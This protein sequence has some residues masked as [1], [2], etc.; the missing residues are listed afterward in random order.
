[1][2]ATTKTLLLA[3]LVAIT[4]WLPS[5]VRA[6][7]RTLTI[8]ITQYP[9][10]LHPSLE[11]MAATMYILGMA[12]RP[13]T[14]YDADW[15]LQCLLCTELPTL[16]NGRAEVE[17]VPLDEGDGSGRGM[18]V[19]YTIRD[20]ATWG[21]GVPIT[22]RDVEFTWQ[23]GR[24]PETGFTAY[25]SYHRIRDVTV[26]DD[27]TFTLHLD[28]VS[29]SYNAIN[30]FRLL[31]AHLEQDA[32]AVPKDYRR[33]STFETDPTNPGLWYGPYTV[34]DVQRGSTVT[35]V[36]N[37]TWWGKAPAFD[38]VVVKAIE[39][40]AALEA[41]LLSGGIDMIAGELGLSVDQAIAFEHRHG[42]DYRVLY[43]PGLF[44]EH[45]D[46]MLDNPVLGDVRVRRALLHA[47]DRQ[48]IVDK[49]FG[50]KL[51][52]AL[53]S[54]SPL[55]WVFSADVPQY[56]YDPDR[57]A[58]LLDES[59]WALGDDGMRSRDGAPLVVTLQ[60]TAGNRSR[61]RVEQ[62]IQAMWKRVGVEAR[63][64]NEPPRVLFAE[65]VTKRRF[66]G[67]VMFAWISSPENTP[68][69][70][71]HCDS[72]PTEENAWIG[73]NYTGYCNPPM[74]A[75]LEDINTELDPETRA[76]LWHELQ[77]LYAADL[78]ALPLWFRAEAYV[79]PE[80]LEGLVPTGHMNY[81]TLW[82][83]DWR[84]ARGGD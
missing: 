42:D 38:R 31:P 50:G 60:T 65:T 53:H 35:L 6:A 83:E 4:A 1:M 66:D 49:L 33:R 46:L 78:P 36:R 47:I 55:D 21:D 57:A 23:V 30:D 11:S 3:F 84:D 75:L 14:A 56:P 25:E 62:V 44:Y 9:Q 7:E 81:S 27:R 41:N 26:V 54:V 67:A 17:P 40:T 70:T 18:A 51:P 79:L 16:E 64:R 5:P 32:F 20:G 63:I 45:L 28:R 22:S 19:T 80:W 12:R 58:A 68:R 61:E 37:P 39:N 34:T 15:R 52:V 69:T 72:V 13:F 8:G 76:G 2:T 24:H 59:G 77:T 73:Q 71:L 29:F 43:R 74:D 48:T 10:T 82:I